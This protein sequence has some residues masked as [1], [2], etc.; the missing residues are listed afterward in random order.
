MLH[1]VYLRAADRASM[2]DALRSAGLMASGGTGMLS[3]AAVDH[4]GPVG[5]DQRHHANMLL[6]SPLSAEQLAVL[7]VIPTP[8]TP[9]R[10]FYAEDVQAP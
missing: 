6:R 5:N 10:G 4:I 7:P 2:E 3:G 8:A 1:I 9:V